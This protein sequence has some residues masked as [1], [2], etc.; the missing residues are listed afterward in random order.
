MKNYYLA[1]AVFLTSFTAF[2]QT[3]HRQIEAKRTNQKVVIDGKLDDAAWKDASKLEDY[4][5]FR[6]T[7]GRKEIKGE[8][9]ET[10]L[11][12]GDE[13]IYFGG[14]CFE[15]KPDSITKELVGRDGFGANDFVVLILDTYN[16]KIN[17][18]EYFVTPLNEQMDSKVTE[19]TSDGDSEDFSWN[20][21]WQSGTKIHDKGWDFEMF[22]PYAAIRFGKDKIQNWGVNV[23]R[24]RTRSQK[25]VAWN[26]V[27]INVNGFLTQ[28]G[29]WTGVKDI[30]PP[31]RLQFFPYFSVYQNHYPASEPGQKS[32]GS[33]V[34]G[35]M[36]LKLGLN[37]AFTLDA[38]LIPDFGQVQSD[39]RVL[40]LTPFEVRFN[41]N[42]TF[43]TEGTELFN[44]G[45]L[46]YSRRIGGD[47]LNGN[48][49]NESL[50][51]NEKIKSMP[52]TARL[53]NASK[54]SGRNQKGLGIGVLNAITQRGYATI[55]NK[56]TGET[57]KVEVDP[58]SNYS[59]V[60]LDQTLKNNSSLSF[61]NSSVIRT[62][63]NYNSNVSLAMVN[64]SN[65]KN[66]YNLTAYG[67][68]SY[69]DYKNESK[70]NDF[71]YSH[72]I[73]AS[74]TSGLV[75]FG[76]TQELT[77]TKYN[78]NDLGYFTN[79]NFI[80][81]SA[82][83]TLRKT[84]PKGWYNRLFV[85][86][87]TYISHLYAPIGAIKTKYQLANFRVNVNAQSKKL[88]WCG[89]FLN[90]QMPQNDFYEPRVQGQFF[91]RGASTGYG[92]W[93][94]T[95][96]GKKYSVN[97]QFFQRNY[98][99]FYK[100]FSGDYEVN[101]SYRFSSKFSVKHGFSYGMKQRNVGF[102]TMIDD[103]TP[104]FAVR[105][106]H[107]IINTLTLKYNFTNKMGLN[108]RARH[109]N[110]N[111]LNK[112]FYSL[113]TNGTLLKN[114]T[115]KNLKD[116]NQNFFNVD[117]VYTWQFAPGSFLNAVWKNSISH[118]GKSTDGYFSSLENTLADNQFNSFS[119]RVIYFLDYLT[120]KNKL[121]K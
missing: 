80:N 91:R 88:F 59:I 15:S 44:K 98:F 25:Q 97:L 96:E 19:N 12:Y 60:V 38:T 103:N 16:D 20:A 51:T 7:M 49:A 118:N 58:M 100:S 75:Q 43:F 9:T 33:Q 101:Q 81:H 117:M 107:T 106:V 120:I 36:D 102:S 77:D 67:T 35:G 13:G 62:G 73:S 78:N 99:Q 84:T 70:K 30:K 37:Q 11:M 50:K 10:F 83:L 92:T 108:L 111:V 6:P 119:L 93:I 2:S 71:G 3:K 113:N 14:T 116:N 54:I 61:V 29:L 17:G 76:L 87:G 42:R 72:S 121:T 112:E 5:E 39:D 85:N 28:A 18:F 32:W 86:G 21:V 64:L 114:E 1:L 52:T 57:R 8:H 34:S 95:N 105:N 65:K 24:R 82:Y 63:G 45:S 48:A 110:S 40:N 109:Y 22:I 79:N 69:L 26:E 46:F 66:S 89:L 31:L 55:E 41:E 53:L 115:N 23:S 27:D 47:I 4:T 56:E 74:K 68:T 94:E 104:L 90:Y